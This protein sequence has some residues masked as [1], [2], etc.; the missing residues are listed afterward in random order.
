MC[1]LFKVT[2]CCVCVCFNAGQTSRHEPVCGLFLACSSL[3]PANA[4]PVSRYNA[5]SSANNTSRES[6]ATTC[7]STE[8]TW[9]PIT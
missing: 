7:G 9:D 3:E 6:I 4:S 5:N 2:R 1:I 8:P